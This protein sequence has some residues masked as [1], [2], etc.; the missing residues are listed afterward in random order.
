MTK[1]VRI[2]NA[3]M[4]DYGVRVTVYEKNAEGHPDVIVAERDL[5]YPTE[6]MNEYLTDTRYM[7]VKEIP[8][9]AKK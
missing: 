7:V 8:G 3:D 2:E 9:P 4:A 1:Y 6:M 5:T